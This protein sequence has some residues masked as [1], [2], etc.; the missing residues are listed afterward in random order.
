MTLPQILSSNLGRTYAFHEASQ[1]ALVDLAKRGGAGNKI[2]L[3][4]TGDRYVSAREEKDLQGLPGLVHSARRKAAAAYLETMKDAVTRWPDNRMTAQVT[5]YLND[6]ASTDGYVKV[7]ELNKIVLGCMRPS[8][9]DVEARSAVF[10]VL[11]NVST[12]LQTAAHTLEGSHTVP[13]ILT[14][15]TEVENLFA[16]AIVEM[17]KKLDLIEANINR[18]EA[19]ADLSSCL[20]AARKQLKKE[21]GDWQAKCQAGSDG[22]PPMEGLWKSLKKQT[23]NLANLNGYDA[24][25]VGRISFNEILPVSLVGVSGLQ[26]AARERLLNKLSELQECG[27]AVQ[28][29]VEHSD[30]LKAEFEALPNSM[31][32]EF[33]KTFTVAIK[34]S[35]LTYGAIRGLRETILNWPGHADD[36]A[37]AA[38]PVGKPTDAQVR[39]RDDL[40]YLL[41]DAR[42]YVDAHPTGNDMTALRVA[43]QSFPS[44]RQPPHLT[45]EIDSLKSILGQGVVKSTDLD[46]VLIKLRNLEGYSTELAA[47]AYEVKLKDSV[48]KQIGK[49]QGW[50]ADQQ[51][52]VAGPASPDVVAQEIQDGIRSIVS[53]ADKGKTERE[54]AVFEEL[55]KKLKPLYDNYAPKALPAVWVSTAERLMHEAMKELT[56]IYN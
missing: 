14:F 3:A 13:D 29:S 10:A 33:L 56:E 19:Q 18:S 15:R 44:K 22:M 40:M 23:K 53:K 42:Q 46:G 49:L 35:P 28:V 6:Q 17:G 24:L 34:A 55:R 27:S 54:H 39:Q 9:K 36:G 37:A 48:L 41:I 1:Q 45:R 30:A 12:K 20:R 47:E 16:D 32:L 11:G 31:G 4:R 5:A 52:S 2:L 43:V 7:A 21:L 8:T 50:W 26:R 51:F 25:Q 38:K